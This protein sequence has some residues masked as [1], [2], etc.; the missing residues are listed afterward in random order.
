[1]VHQHNIC[2]IVPKISLKVTIRWR[3]K[4][5]Y[6]RECGLL[7]PHCPAIITGHWYQKQGFQW[8]YSYPPPT[9]PVPQQRCTQTET[10]QLIHTSNNNKKT[11]NI[12]LESLTFRRTMCHKTC[13]WIIVAHLH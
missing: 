11:A 5:M 10:L 7:R 12:V 6:W 3:I 13:G 2:H 4:V 1:M 9:H 8:S